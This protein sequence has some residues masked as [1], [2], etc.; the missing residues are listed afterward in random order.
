[1]NAIPDA[2]PVMAVCAC[3]AEGTTVLHNVP[4]ARIKETD[5]I[6]VMAA[7]LTKLGADI[8]ELPDG[9]IIRGTGLR[10]GRVHGHADHRVVMALALAGFAA[11]SPV[12][13]DTAESADVTYPGFWDMMRSLGGIMKIGG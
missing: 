13:V 2:I 9:L 3:F 10:G 7:E 1:M 8:K 5:R 4:Q 11:D 6:A 12:T